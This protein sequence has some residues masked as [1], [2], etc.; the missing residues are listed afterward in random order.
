MATR[1]RIGI[2][3][4]RYTPWRGEF[5]PPGL[6]ERE[7]LAYAAQRFATIEL[8]GSFYSLQ[9]PEYYARWFEQVP[10]RFV[11]AVKGSRYIT[12]MLR[13]KGVETALANFFASGV[14]KLEHKL[15]PLLWQLPPTLKFDEQRI[16]H[17]LSLLPR[18]TKEAARLARRHDE[19][20]AGRSYLRVVKERKLRHALEVR[21]PSFATPQAVQLLR[22]QDVALVVA[23]TAG[24]WPFLEDVTSDFVYVR[25]HGDAKLYESGYTDAAL[26]RWAARV[27][28][29]RD[30]RPFS[31]ATLA[32]EPPRRARR[33]DVYVYFDNDIKVHAPYDA[34]SLAAKVAARTSH[35]KTRHESQQQAQALPR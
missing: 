24:R 9:R 13:L 20:V 28:A 15:G 10:A 6:P 17:F 4:W 3:G 12:H 8:N 25:L 29:W 33:R 2:S 14:L 7:E 11:F 21:H 19:R 18:T 32:A 5:Y 31:G 30:G 22:D 16:E 27:R 26:E 34:Q 1:A 23:D 35:E